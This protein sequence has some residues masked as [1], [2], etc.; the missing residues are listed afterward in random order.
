MIGLDIANG[1]TGQFWGDFIIYAAAVL[2]AGGVVYRKVISPMVNWFRRFLALTERIVHAMEWVEAEFG[3]ALGTLQEID[4]RL[5]ELDT[6]MD[7]LEELVEHD[8][9]S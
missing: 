5:E 4:Y 6:R 9:D 2:T 3:S 1:L 8:S 7:I